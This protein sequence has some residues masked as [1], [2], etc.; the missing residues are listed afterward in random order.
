MRTLHALLVVVAV[1]CAPTLKVKPAEMTEDLQAQMVVIQAG[2]ADARQRCEPLQRAETSFAEERAIG[3][4]L[5]TRLVANT[6]HLFLDGATEKDP[7]K[8]NDELANRKS[9]ALPEGGRNAVSAHVAI[10]GRNL[11]RYS[12]RP[13]LPWVFGVLESETAAAF[14]EPGGYVFVTTGLLKKMTNEAQLAGVLAHEIGHVVHKHGLNRYREVKHQQCVA[15]RFA[16]YVI[17][18][19]G[20]RSPATDGMAAFARNFEAS[21]DLDAADDGF[22]AF[23]MNT[24]MTLMQ[25]GHDKES[26]FQTDRT[27]LELVSFAGYEAQE[28]ERFLAAFAQPMHPAAA[29]RAAKLTALRE[30]EL[31]DF[32]HGTAK[33]DLAK[34]F[35]PLGK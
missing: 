24:M 5:S 10:V 23:L 4:W 9:L 18:H 7:Q 31:K 13:D 19:G 25:L 11:A 1:S 30:G 33:P 22:V 26:E 2:Q 32:V 14:N 21:F 20:P 3:A 28:Y 17:E 16:A 8:L 34:V 12:A 15:A 35:G 6:G 27:A 29:D